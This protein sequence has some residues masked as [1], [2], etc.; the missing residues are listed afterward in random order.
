MGDL[1]LSSGARHNERTSRD[2]P[3]LEKAVPEFLF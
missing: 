1:P 3:E 2:L